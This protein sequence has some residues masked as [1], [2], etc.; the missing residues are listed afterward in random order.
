MTP[1]SISSFTRSLPLFI[2][3]GSGWLFSN[4]AA[5]ARSGQREYLADASAVEFTPNPVALIRALKQIAR[6]ESP[7]K[8]ALRG[9][10]TLFIVDPFEYGGSM[11][12]YL[13]SGP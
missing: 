8:A 6:N 7:L 9:L 4:R 1:P 3:G 2:A 13:H 11:G 5:I 10:A 12:I